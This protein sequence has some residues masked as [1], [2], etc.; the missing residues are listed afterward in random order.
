MAVFGV[1]ALK[2]FLPATIGRL[3]GANPRTVDC[4]ALAP[5]VAH[6]T[7]VKG[8]G[9]ATLAGALLAADPVALGMIC[10]VWVGPT[11]R[12]DH[13]RGVLVAC[14][15]YPAARWL[16]GRGR[17]GVVLGAA[18]PALLVYARLRGTGWGKKRLTLRLLWKRLECDAELA[19]DSGAAEA[20]R[21]GVAARA[22]PARRQP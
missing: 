3:A 17:Q 13:A 1:D 19:S 2:G 14:A 9:V 10:P 22:D 16:L 5:V 20:D 8:K 6:I 12:K 15:L 11:L 7:V 21:Q 4:L 18:A